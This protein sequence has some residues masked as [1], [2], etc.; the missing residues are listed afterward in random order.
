MRFRPSLLAGSA[1]L[2]AMAVIAGATAAS[3][4]DRG[5][6]GPLFAQATPP[7]APPP[8][9]GAPDRPVGPP[10]DRPAGMHG[11]R[12]FSPK[13]MCQEQVARRVG[14]R[15][16]LKTRLDLKPEQMAAWTAFET[17]ADEAAAKSKA[18]C[19]T[20][21][22]DIM[23]VASFADRM[24]L[25]EDAMKARLDAFQTVRPSLEALYA[26]LTPEQQALFER[27]RGRRHG[28]H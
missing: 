27:P 7:V 25:R 21:P 22:D 1:V 14:N 8:V 19:A 20:L 16:Y 5:F 26:V 24:A 10:A 4:L 13:A 12:S 15:A 3:A 17:A 23:N 18:R 11:M 28:P 6:H 2:A 9:A